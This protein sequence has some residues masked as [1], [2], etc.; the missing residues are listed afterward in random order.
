MSDDAR[1]GKCRMSDGARILAGF[2]RSVHPFI[3]SFVMRQATK[4]KRSQTD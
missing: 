1:W 3:F 4:M 2:A